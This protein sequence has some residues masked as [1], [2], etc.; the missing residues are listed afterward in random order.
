VTVAQTDRGEQLQTD[1]VLIDGRIV[2]EGSWRRASSSMGWVTSRILRT[3][4]VG[5]DAEWE[6]EKR[7][8]QKR[9]RQTSLSHLV[10]SL[11]LLKI[12]Q[13][14]WSESFLQRWRKWEIY[15]CVWARER[16]RKKR[17][18]ALGGGQGR[19]GQGGMKSSPRDA[20]FVFDLSDPMEDWYI[21][22]HGTLNKSSGGDWDCVWERGRENRKRL[23]R[24]MDGAEKDKETWLDWSES[25]RVAKLGTGEFE[26]ES[27]V[28]EKCEGI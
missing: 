3:Y 9:D 25:P 23:D 22:K 13:R 15:I 4:S 8:D 20:E 18:M 19:L 26:R 10:T 28:A 7:Q 12:E 5:E 16:E 27:G 11:Y 17:E 6:Q 1:G 24:V 14:G 2:G 21:L